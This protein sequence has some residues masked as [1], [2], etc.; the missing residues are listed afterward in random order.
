LTGARS[1][2]G[3]AVFHT[4]G[5]SAA[6]AAVVT[7]VRSGSEMESVRRRL[8]KAAPRSVCHGS[9]GKPAEAAREQ[10]SSQRGRYAKDRARYRRESARING[11]QQL[12][13]RARVGI[14]RIGRGTQQIEESVVWRH[15]A[16]WVA[17]GVSQ[18]LVNNVD[19]RKFS[20]GVGQLS[21]RLTRSGRRAVRTARAFA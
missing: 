13:I 19:V 18:Q 9:A 12:S 10:R 1:V 16:G 14:G 21:R 17:D 2:T 5:N 11:A 4:V 15:A 7:S 20:V 6:V 3:F 8:G